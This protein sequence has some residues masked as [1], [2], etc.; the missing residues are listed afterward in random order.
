MSFTVAIPDEPILL[1]VLLWPRHLFDVVDRPMDYAINGVAGQVEI[2]FRTDLGTVPRLAEVFVVENDD[3]EWIP[4]FVLHDKLCVTRGDLATGVHYTSEEA[5]QILKAA[6][7]A[8]GAEPLRAEA[9]YLAVR[10]FGP[11]WT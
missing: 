6:G 3:A 11:Q 5:A 9:I 8:R 4:G 7:L 10:D 1:P 2:G